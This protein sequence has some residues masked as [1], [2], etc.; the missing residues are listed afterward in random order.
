MTAAHDLVDR[1]E[2]LGATFTVREDRVKLS[3]PSPLPPEMMAE[4][5]SLKLEIIE[6]LR[7]REQT[8]E[9][10]SPP[11]PGPAPQTIID[12]ATAPPPEVSKAESPESLARLEEFQLLRQQFSE[13]EPASSQPD[14]V[15]APSSPTPARSEEKRPPDSEESDEIA[16]RRQEFERLRMEAAEPEEPEPQV[17]ID[18]ATEP[19]QKVSEAESP[20]SLARQKSSSFSASSSRR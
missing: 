15:D 19:Q 8:D 14:T 20:E 9:P 3:G 10:E 4:L 5:R 17:I 13:A 12:S 16:R 11:R 1:A 2:A 18:S 7:Q 6:Y